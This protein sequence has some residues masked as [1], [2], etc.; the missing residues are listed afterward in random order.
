MFIV[1]ID[2][3]KINLPNIRFDFWKESKYTYYLDSYNNHSF[4]ECTGDVHLKYKKTLTI[5]RFSKLSIIKSFG[6]DEIQLEKDLVAPIMVQLVRGVPVQDE[7]EASLPKVDPRL[8]VKVLKYFLAHRNN[9]IVEHGWE[10]GDKNCSAVIDHSLD[11][12]NSKIC[13]IKYDLK[14]CLGNLNDEIHVRT[15]TIK[16]DEANIKFIDYYY[17]HS[18]MEQKRP[19]FQTSLKITF[20]G[21]E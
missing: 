1:T 16:F 20:V 17:Q 3:Q 5:F 18:L 2:S 9:K 13:D 6:L 11:I 21:Y 14:E 10:L 15:I 12:D 7:S 19:V 8:V 4:L